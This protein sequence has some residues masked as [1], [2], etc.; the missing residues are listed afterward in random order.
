MKI[1][2]FQIPR[3]YAKYKSRLGQITRAVLTAEKKRIKEINLV[4]LD[5]QAM[6]KMNHKFLNRKYST[7]VLS[8]RLTADFGE[9]YI[10]SFMITDYRH[11][12]EL[13]LH[14]LL[15]LVGF[16]HRNARERRIMQTR[17]DYY[18]AKY[19]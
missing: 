11:L 17:T 4:F 18:L 3:K 6:L 14:G 7:D 13:I 8:F 15:H 1:R 2:L 9:I 19:F 10:N 12:G 5:N 16:D